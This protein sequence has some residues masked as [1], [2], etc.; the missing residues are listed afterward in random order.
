[1]NTFAIVT[2]SSCDLPESLAREIDL[3][4]LPLAFVMNGREYYNYLDER[5]ILLH[6]FYEAL[7]AGQPCTTSAVNVDAFVSAMEPLLKQGR[8]VL[9]IAFSS[10]LS[11]TYNA[12]ALAVEE[13]AQKYPERKIY[14][15]DSLCASL[16]Q[17]LLI[18]L[19]AQ[20]R[21]KGKPIEEVRDWVEKEK[22]HLCHWFTVEDLQ[23]L[24][25]GGRVSAA[26]ALVGTMLSIKP[27]MHMDNAGHLINISKARGR[28]ASLRALVDRME[29]LAIQPEEQTVFISHGDS[30]EDAQFV[31]NE[32]QSRLGVQKPITINYVGPVIGAHSGPGTI[33]LFFLGK[34][35]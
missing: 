4:V 22:Y 8:D 9:C 24:K 7:R 5:E 29:Q 32:V 16:G 19:A 25:R 26:T 30:L 23:F 13:L 33:A 1:M 15:V 21:S 17:G 20:E 12:A 31:A 2:D 28:K 34:E 10:G 11:N 14:A 6:D 3:T 35:R 27:V 18:Y